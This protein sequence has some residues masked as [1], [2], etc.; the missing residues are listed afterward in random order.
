MRY[1]LSLSVHVDT[2]I[3]PALIIAALLDKLGKGFLCRLHVIDR[4][5]SRCLRLALSGL[6]DQLHVVWIIKER[7]KSRLQAA[8]FDQ[9][10]ILFT[11]ILVFGW[12]N[13][14]GHLFLCRITLPGRNVIHV[15]LP[16]ILI[17]HGIV[18]LLVKYR[19]VVEFRNLCT[20][21]HRVERNNHVTPLL[22]QRPFHALLVSCHNDNTHVGVLLAKCDR[23]L[24]IR[25]L[26]GIDLVMIAHALGINGNVDIHA[27]RCE[28]LGKIGVLGVGKSLQTANGSIGDLLHVLN[29]K[30]A[31]VVREGIPAQAVMA[32]EV[33][34]HARAQAENVTEIRGIL[35]LLLCPGCALRVFEHIL[36]LCS[37][38]SASLGK[39]LAALL[40]GNV[41]RRQ[42]ML[43]ILGSI[44]PGAI[45]APHFVGVLA[46]VAEILIKLGRARHLR[47][48][49]FLVGGNSL[50]ALADVAQKHFV[51]CLS[52]KRYVAVKALRLLGNI[53]KLLGHQ[54]AFHLRKR[55]VNLFRNHVHKSIIRK[56]ADTDGRVLD[57]H[58][59]R[60]VLDQRLAL[61]VLGKDFF[62]RLHHANHAV[63]IRNCLV[64]LLHRDKGSVLRRNALVVSNGVGV[65]QAE[66]R[67]VD[68][69]RHLCL[70]GKRN[71]VIAAIAL[72]KLGKHLFV[73]VQQLPRLARQSLV[74][75]IISCRAAEEIQ[76]LL[77]EARLLGQDVLPSIDVAQRVLNTGRRDLLVNN[78]Q[79]L[80]HAHAKLLVEFLIF[81][82]DLARSVRF[83]RLKCTRDQAN[84]LG[85]SH[86]RMSR[87][88]QKQLVFHSA[89][90]GFGV[91]VNGV[92]ADARVTRAALLGG[93]NNVH[94]RSCRHAAKGQ[95]RVLVHTGCECLSHR[96]SHGRT[97]RL[98]HSTP[99]SNVLGRD[100][101]QTHRL[102]RRGALRG[103]FCAYPLR[104]YLHRLLR[105]LCGLCCALRIALRVPVR[106]DRAVNLCKRQIS[107]WVACLVVIK[108]VS[109]A[110]A[111][112]CH[113]HSAV[114]AC[115]VRQALCNGIGSEQPR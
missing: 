64:Q 105:V 88:V 37:L 86:Q 66:S 72:R 67:I 48:A 47:H 22:R 14:L 103:S 79:I 15:S 78:W 70:I 92:A 3:V 44:D 82:R 5:E 30:C 62:V 1:D 27:R 113:V 45:S 106:T 24:Q 100:H 35:C 9:L 59:I 112:K 99:V 32:V 56:R 29:D 74:G 83:H 93:E 33:V 25:T 7:R 75:G 115:V 49:G 85:L 81:L 43:T 84:T 101:I 87:L 10:K 12:I 96:H 53:V 17:L 76:E 57:G 89:I 111:Q 69:P 58:V 95:R 38:V 23:L 18:L 109:V 28:D 39:L 4:L 63:C 51:V 11:I 90:V 98:G 110:L 114:C 108:V 65:F 97:V 91:N 19:P 21:S 94:A 6:V 13:H 20:G 42:Q 102:C 34:D 77:T 50:I 16:Q 61:F 107:A 41:I 46:L 2:V 26:L 55:T 36:N 40:G 71:G 8:L 31:A 54:K 68:I 52:V 73:C 60:S 80:I 104:L